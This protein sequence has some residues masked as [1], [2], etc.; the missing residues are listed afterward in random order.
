MA[1]K[2]APLTPKSLSDKY[3]KLNKKYYGK[4]VT[5]DNLIRYE[6]ARIPHFYTAFYVYKYAT[7]LT[8]AVNI[9][10]AILSKGDA[11]VA[12]YKKFLQSGGSDSPYELLKIAGVDLMQKAPFERAMN[13]FKNTLELLKKELK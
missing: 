4:A 12:N 10:N 11:A 8:A 7:G 6:W 5:H 1:A 2:G 13:E 3:Y 9:A